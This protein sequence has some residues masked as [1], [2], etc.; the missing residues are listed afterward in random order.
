[1]RNLGKERTRGALNTSPT[2]Y[3]MENL[4]RYASKASVSKRQHT[5]HNETASD[6]FHR[7]PPKPG[8]QFSSGVKLVSTA[9]EAWCD[10]NFVEPARMLLPFTACFAPGTTNSQLN[11]VRALSLMSKIRASPL[12]GLPHAGILTD[13]DGMVNTKDGPRN[14]FSC[15]ADLPIT[16][17]LSAFRS[18][19]SR[20]KINTVTEEW[21]L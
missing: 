8:F 4:T 20:F 9:Q 10:T 12:D 13:L 2:E 18:S 19:A 16:Y 15:S 1:M 5:R 3:L 7:T 11:R 21:H 14:K 17:Y 6:R